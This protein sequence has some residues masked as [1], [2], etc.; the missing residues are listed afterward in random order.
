MIDINFE[1]KK[2]IMKE[3]INDWQT[4]S[5]LTTNKDISGTDRIML[6][7]VYLRRTGN[8]KKIR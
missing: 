5:D 8:L 4:F 7:N 6:F 2:L 1:K 3:V